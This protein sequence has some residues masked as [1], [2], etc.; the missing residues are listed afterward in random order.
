MKKG[1]ALLIIAILTAGLALAGC[2]SNKPSNS[3]ADQSP[4]QE[5]NAKDESFTIRL[6]AWSIDE[7]SV[8]QE[9]KKNI[10][11]KYKELYPNATIQWDITLS[12]SYFDKLK[13]ELASNTAADV[14]FS[15]SDFQNF[16]AAGY[17]SDLSDQPWTSRLHP[18]TKK[19]TTA[20]GKVY[21]ATLGMGGSGIWYNK[22]IFDDLGLTP[23]KTW[24]DFISLGEKI[25][26]AGITPMA[27]GFKDMWTVSMFLTN[28]GN[29][30]L[31]GIAP[32]IGKQYYDGTKTLDGPEM[33]AVMGK[34]QE[35]TQKG[36][37][38]Q[39]ALTSDWTQSADLFTSGKA[40]MITQGSYMPAAA[41]D[42]FKNK[43]HTPFE[44]GYFQFP[45]ENG[46]YNIVVSSGESISVNAKSKLQQQAKDLISVI[47][48]DEVLAPYIIGNGSLPP[49]TDME[50]SY[51]DVALN[52]FL[53][54]V[55]KGKTNLGINNY[56]PS[57][58]YSSLQEV[59]TK[60]VSG[61]KFDSGDLKDAQAKLEKDKATVILPEE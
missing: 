54:Y 39:T 44:V 34:V 36:F 12:S 41:A 26:D 27:L 30:Q 18:G 35:L 5:G 48:S 1:V 6:S 38:N 16:V 45:D 20:G 11:E 7:R 28:L 3:S 10:T 53:D 13:A 29:S 42:N 51:P 4:K 59:V 60:I 40:A 58:A 22:K 55:N 43:G 21:G 2:S 19:A 37:F 9:F 14:I 31:Y 50:V 57:S 23:P 49:Y 47:V 33:Q 15:Q 32:A 25:E 24:A 52:D 46:F 56:V 61:V 17:F 8:S